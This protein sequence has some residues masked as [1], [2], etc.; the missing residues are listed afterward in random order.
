MATKSKSARSV[1]LVGTKRAGE[2]LGVSDSR[3]RQLVGNHNQGE[4]PAV[5]LGLRSWMISVV[6]IEKYA[7]AN[8]ITVNYGPFPN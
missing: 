2:M 1:E 4:L 6:E 7:K 5:R 3:I 8:G